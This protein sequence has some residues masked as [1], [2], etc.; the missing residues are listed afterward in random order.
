MLGR[1]LLSLLF[2]KA[3][4]MATSS[5]SMKESLFS[6]DQAPLVVFLLLK[7]TLIRLSFWKTS[8]IYTIIMM[9][10]NIM[11]NLPC[12]LLLPIKDSLIVEVKLKAGRVL[13]LDKLMQGIVLILQVK[14]WFNKNLINQPQMFHIMNNQQCLEH[15]LSL[16]KKTHQQN[17]L[18]KRSKSL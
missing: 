13:C 12:F 15:R 17:K 7:T 4:E 5:T 1:R 10:A 8:T 2:V 16:V 9:L 14:D 11:S 18:R 6:Q 3:Q